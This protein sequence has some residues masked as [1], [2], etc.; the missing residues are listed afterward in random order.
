MTIEVI[1]AEEPRRLVTRIVD[2]GLPFGGTWTYDI[3][4]I[5]GGSRVTIT[6]DGWIGNP[7][8]RFFARYVF[9]MNRTVDEALRG[10]G[11]RF[12]ET[13]LPAEVPG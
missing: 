10:L 5:D 6:E 3:V 1:G 12:G 13:V 9:G 8:F 7:L 4:P 11:E 2:D